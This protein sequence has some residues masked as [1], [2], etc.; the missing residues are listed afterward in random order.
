MVTRRA[1]RHREGAARPWLRFRAAAAVLFAAAFLPVPPAASA[2][3]GSIT[4][5]GTRTGFAWLVVRRTMT[6]DLEA[7]TV[8][9]DGAYGG[10]AIARDFATMWSK[11]DRTLPTLFGHSSSS[12]VLRPGRHKVRLFAEAGHRV[13]VTI[14]WTGPDVE[15][16]PTHPVDAKVYAGATRVLPSRA[17]GTTALSF[18]QDGR[19][20][21]NTGMMARVYAAVG[22][23]VD[24]A[25]CLTR[26]PGTCEGADDRLT[27]PGTGIG[28]NDRG[29]AWSRYNW[30][31]PTRGLYVRGEVSG[32]TAGVLRV[33]V[34]RFY[35]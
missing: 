29:V 30:P 35:P 3:E 21:A 15:L 16:R 22:L 34:L 18:L 14:P 19:A 31:W 2:D 23:T 17:T 1:G 32:D 8:D 7:A 13:T 6:Y 26:D 12:G 25:L 28:L 33:F 10:F 20:G 5:T 9:Y 11:Y 27:Q 24:L 4:V